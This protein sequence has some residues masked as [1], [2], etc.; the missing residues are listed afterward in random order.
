MKTSYF[1]PDAW[2]NVGTTFD[3]T[4]Q[5]VIDY[6]YDIGLNDYPI[7][8]EKRRDWLNE[9]I[10]DHFRFREIA[11]ETPLLFCNWI[12]R[13]MREN[14]PFI[15]PFFETAYEMTLEA[16]R[17][18]YRMERDTTEN[19]A[20]TAT[21]ESSATTE[22]DMQTDTGETGSL[23]HTDE[24]SSTV[25]GDTTSY[26]STNPKQTMVN[27]DTTLY[28]DAGTKAESSTTNSASD[29]MSET[30]SRDVEDHTYG[31][32]STTETDST[33]TNTD[34]TRHELEHGIT[35]NSITEWLEAWS[36]LS[37]TPVKMVFQVLEPAFCQLWSSHFNSF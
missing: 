24:A 4:L 37:I 18:N 10:I 31:T 1:G 36:R 16:L 21:D 22:T 33:I 30:T 26:S 20:G 23:T 14:M 34:R 28:Y 29:D 13:L 25:S 5:D 9:M 6:G 8:D 32:Q 17:E 2:Q 15:N 27:K 12:N 11:A 3:M 7:W 35:G 19:I